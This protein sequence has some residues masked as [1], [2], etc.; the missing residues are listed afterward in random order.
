MTAAIPSVPSPD[1]TVA[2]ALAAWPVLVPVFLHRRMAC[3]GCAMAPFMTLREAAESYGVD[4]DAL[5]ADLI[6]AAAGAAVPAGPFP[7]PLPHRAEAADDG[8]GVSAP[9]PGG[10]VPS[11]R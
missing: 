7:P 5:V 2:E 4:A 11:V 10:A 9:P 8:V 3:P 1:L 6:A